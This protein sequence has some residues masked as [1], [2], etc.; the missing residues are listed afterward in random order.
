MNT[1]SPWKR[2]VT[3]HI[4][5]P[6]KQDETREYS[7]DSSADGV[8]KCKIEDLI[9]SVR[10]IDNHKLIILV[11][12]SRPETHLGKK[13]GD[14]VSAF[15][16]FIEML[17]TASEDKSAKDVAIYFADVAKSVLPEKTDVFD[18]ISLKFQ[19][20]A[21]LR[22][23]RLERKALTRQLRGE[24]Q[25]VIMIKKLKT[26][27]K[28]A[29]RS[30]IKDLIQEM[31]EA[32]LKQL[33]TEKTIAF[34]KSGNTDRAEGPAVKKAVH[35]LKAINQLEKITKDENVPDIILEFFYHDYIKVGAKYKDGINAVAGA[36]G[37]NRAINSWNN[38]SASKKYILE[39]LHQ[40]TK[41]EKIAGFFGDLFD[42]DCD[43]HQESD[44]E[45]LYEV[46]A[47]HLVIM[48]HAFDSLQKYNDE[49]IN[50]II[51]IFLQK[52]VLERSLWNEHEAELNIESLNVGI[53]K[54]SELGDGVF[55]MKRREQLINRDFQLN[56][57]G[58]EL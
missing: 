53:K 31:G 27:L 5:T 48:F 15:I 10:E 39:G 19:E 51:D 36:N 33:N 56:Q 23:S 12:N 49:S 6:I 13:Q 18:A 4:Y 35:A 3:R 44:L 50:N 29:E 55:R 11:S 20:K 17:V 57:R 41:P 24:S 8:A 26:S 40:N 16:S 21:S 1:P 43:K 46:T 42:F 30:M 28:D 37:V 52:E 54:Y 45:L 9:L 58:I 34:K 2:A 7:S 32:F 38:T 22:Y 14:H 47:R 25:D